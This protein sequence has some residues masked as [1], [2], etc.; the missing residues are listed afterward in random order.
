[1]FRFPG[2]PRVGRRA[3]IAFTAVALSASVAGASTT[4]LFGRVFGGSRNV[5]SLWVSGSDNFV[6]VRGDGDTDLDCWL[7]DSAGRLVSSDTDSTDFCVLPAPGVGT[8]RVAIR[9]LGRVYNDY[10]IWTEN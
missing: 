1:M 8:H 10:A 7:Y 2:F 5:H 3:V 6:M 4:T 9:N